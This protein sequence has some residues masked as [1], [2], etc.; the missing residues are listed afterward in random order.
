MPPPT[1]L[2]DRRDSISSANDRDSRDSISSAAS[3][4]NK[5]EQVDVK[6]DAE[7]V[8]TQARHRQ[9][10]SRSPPSARSIRFS[11]AN[12]GVKDPTNESERLAFEMMRKS[13]LKKR[14]SELQRLADQDAARMAVLESVKMQYGASSGGRRA[15]ELDKISN[16]SRAA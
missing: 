9:T 11:M 2:H 13:E 16:N 3:A 4:T 12:K 5:N 14:Q 7:Q 6:V 8:G 1:L 15:A 10:K